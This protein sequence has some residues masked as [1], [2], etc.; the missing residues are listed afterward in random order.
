MKNGCLDFDLSKLMVEIK[1]KKY[2]PCARSFVTHALFHNAN[3]FGI[4]IDKELLKFNK[5]KRKR[6]SSKDLIDVEEGTTK[7]ATI[8]ELLD[9]YDWRFDV[10][11][12]QNQNARL[13]FIKKKKSIPLLKQL[14]R[15]KRTIDDENQIA[16]SRGKK[17]KVKSKNKSNSGSDSDSDSD[18]DSEVKSEI[19][20]DENQ[21]AKSRDKKAKQKRN[22]KRGNVRSSSISSSSC[23][24]SSSSNSDSDSDVKSDNENDSEKR[25]R[26]R[27]RKK[28]KHRKVRVGDNSNSESDS[29]TNITTSDKKM[30]KSRNSDSDDSNNET[31]SDDLEILSV[32]KSKRKK[33]S[34][35]VNSNTTDTNVSDDP[36]IPSSEPPE[37]SNTSLQQRDTN[38]AAPHQQFQ[39]LI[40]TTDTNCS[41]SG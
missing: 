24:S 11:L 28:L 5:T 22:V 15:K 30:K 33:K 18:S 26:R 34:K 19:E 40:A 9:H 31:G 4:N 39:H 16:R 23:S 25:K 20:S 27:R 29:D 12:Q 10:T 35:N 13:K 17:E 32:N 7:F 1:W 2:D 36:S 21:I 14:Y 3:N 6:R 8:D 38:L 37:N 41:S